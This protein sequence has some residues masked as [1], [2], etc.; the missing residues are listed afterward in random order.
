MTDKAVH[1]AFYP[2]D[3]LAGTRG[4]TPAE[5]GIYITLTCMMYERQAPLPFDNRR[6]ARICNC[7]AGSFKQIIASLI[8]H[9][10][11]IET[12]EGLWQHRV[13][14]EI[15]HAR[16]AMR[17]ASERAKRGADAR[18]SRTEGASG[19][20]EN[21]TTKPQSGEQKSERYTP[22]KLNEISDS[23]MPEQCPSNANQNQN[24]NQ[25]IYKAAAEYAREEISP[26]LIAKL[27]HA[28]GFD[29]QGVVPKYWASPD[30]AMIVSRWQTD[31]GLTHDEIVH[32]AAANMRM[33]GA[34]ANG[35]KILTRHMQ[36]FAAAK[37]A[38]PL[39]PATIP[40]PRPARPTGHGIKAQI[41][42]RHRK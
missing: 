1:I 37:N 16:E 8:E 3:W 18:W 39:T 20:V 30:A 25:N 13:G 34:P 6:L 42:E 2:S 7:P 15:A 21:G 32:V 27:T 5:T 33:H 22:E 11:L 41:P 36:D 29:L 38:P 24:Q 4:L 19:G 12:P 35:P 9:G 23:N 14:E 26:S 28:L 40:D 17:V 10:K 31:L